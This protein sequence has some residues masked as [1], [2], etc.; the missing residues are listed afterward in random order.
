MLCATLILIS[1][2]L[3]CTYC[4]MDIETQGLN[5]VECLASTPLKMNG[6]V[7]LYQ[8]KCEQRL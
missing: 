8:W 1:Y 4:S 3:G 6:I 5:F 2:C 7:L